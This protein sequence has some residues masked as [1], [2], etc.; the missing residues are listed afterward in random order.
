MSNFDLNQFITFFR[1]INKYDIDQGLEFSITHP[2][3]VSYKM[4][5]LEKHLSSPNTAHGAAIA[6]FMDCVL[7]LS[8]LSMA[9]TEGN[10]TS[11]VEFK[12]NYIRPV[13]LGE[14]IFGTGK[15]VHKGKSLIISSAEI[16]NTKGELVAMGQGTFNTYPFNKKDYLNDFTSPRT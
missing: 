3:N 1:S 9:V 8:A 6:G 11:T 5:I 13:S 15:V 12:I 10:L 14:E 4:Q 16:K 2:G 7:G